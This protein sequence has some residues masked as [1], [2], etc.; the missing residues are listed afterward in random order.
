[1][2]LG[3]F[4]NKVFNNTEGL[5]HCWKA[6]ELHCG[7]W[8]EKSFILIAAVQCHYID[9]FPNSHVCT[10]KRGLQPSVETKV[11]EKGIYILK[12]SLI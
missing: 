6:L 5:Q 7:E 11:T 9:W 3:Y 12:E 1:M 4:K 10:V 2:N 8:R